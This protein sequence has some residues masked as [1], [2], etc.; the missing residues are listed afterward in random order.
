MEDGGDSVDSFDWNEFDVGFDYAMTS[1]RTR[2]Y[3]VAMSIGSVS[4]HPSVSNQ[5]DVLY[6]QAE[7]RESSPLSQ[8]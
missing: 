6:S 7:E 8:S 4:K 1:V 3:I 2:R 5:V